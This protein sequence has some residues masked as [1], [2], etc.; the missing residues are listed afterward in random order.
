[1]KNALRTLAILALISGRASAVLIVD[2]NFDGYETQA[3]FEAVWAPT[4][5]VVPISNVHSAER[6][7]SAP[8][9]VE[10]PATSST[11]QY[12]N[13]LAFAPTPLLGIGD[14]LVWS[15]D[16]YD[17]LPAGNPRNNFASLQTAAVPGASPAGQ[18][19]SMGL[20]NNQTADDS[21]GNRYMAGILGYSHPAVDPD[22]GPDEAASG[23]GPGAFFKL[24][25][26]EA[27]LRGSDDGWHHLKLVLSTGN[28]T[29]VDHAYYVDDTLA[30]TVSSA[31][32]ILKYSVIQLGSGLAN[33]SQGVNFDNMRLE[34]IAAAIPEASSFAAVGLVGL[35]AGSAAWLRRRRVNRAHE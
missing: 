19:I 17:K 32:P 7:L 30:E 10:G 20:S 14:Q 8:Y 23:T 16:Y 12:Q 29:T 25:D 34:F 5:T 28:G 26:T 9:S 15:F 33:G 1:M 3:Q 24:N 27:A 22:G 4:G 21:G 31:G 6:A 35:L 11:G 18:R 2:D 13:Q